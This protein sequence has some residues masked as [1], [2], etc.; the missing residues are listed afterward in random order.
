MRPWWMVRAGL[1]LYDLLSSRG[2]LPRSRRVRQPDAAL[3][4]SGRL[5]LYWDAWVDDARL[6]VLNAVDAAERG[7]EIAT[8][9]EFLSARREGE[10][11]RAALSGGGREVFAKA[12]VNAAGPWVADVLHGRLH[13]TSRSRARL[14]KGSH[15]L[16]PRLS[17]A[18]HAYILQQPD[19]RVVFAL[20]FGEFTIV[21]TT[22]VPVAAPGEAAIEAGE[23]E[24][25]C[26]AANLYF[27]RQTRPA[28]VIWSYSGIR[29]LYD[30]GAADAKAVT[31]D[32]RLELDPDPGPKLLSV[33]GGKI[34]T[35]RALAEEALDRLGIGGRTVTD[36]AFLPGGDILPDF[37][38]WLDEIGTWLPAP[39]VLRLSRAYG[40]RLRELLAGAAS[41]RDLGRHFGA[42]LYEVEARYLSDREFAR[43]AEDMLWRRTKLGLHM[44]PPI[45]RPSPAGSRLRGPREA[46]RSRAAGPRP[47]P[48]G[49]PR[50]APGSSGPR[51]ARPPVRADGPSCAPSPL[52]TP[53]AGTRSRRTRLNGHGTFRTA[54]SCPGRHRRHGDRLEARPRPAQG[55]SPPVPAALPQRRCRPCDSSPAL[56]P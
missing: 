4:T 12:I 15:I 43:T 7:A 9:T 52:R 42:G 30:D 2:G 55:A 33:F 39:L 45:S 10:L 26:A 27:E 25:L 47:S 11:W 13:E 19:G 20:P 23:I 24:Y 53:E 54:S 36:T 31:R 8:R 41:V 34:T 14:V 40:T 6:V 48:C 18:D 56:V 17:E 29:S 51:G 35:A 3:R 32:Y 1:L 22:D 38:D 44:A 46:D 28:D 37:L 21:G 16:V 49:S 50:P 5:A